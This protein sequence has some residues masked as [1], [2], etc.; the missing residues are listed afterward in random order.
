MPG[1]AC[2]GPRYH[3]NDHSRDVL[4][5]R[6]R[7]RWTSRMRASARRRSMRPASRW[8]RIAARS[9]DFADRAAS[10]ALYRAEIIALVQRCRAPIWC[11]ST[12]PASC[13]SA[14]ARRTPGRWTIRGPRALRMSTSAMRPPPHSRS[15]PLPP[16]DPLA[17]FVHYN[18]WRALS[19]PPQDVPLA[20]CDARSVRR[21]GSDRRRRGIRRAGRAGV[22]VRGHRA[23]ARP[24][25]SLALVSGHARER[26]AGL[27]DPRQ[28]PGRAH[29]VP[30]VAFDN[31]PARRMPPRRAPASRCARSPC[32]SPE[33]RL[34]NSRHPRA[35]S[36]SPLSA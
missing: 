17:R 21:R 29:C 28:R 30:H 6:S 2:R 26:G 7:W 33:T 25:A 16:T 27:Q 5:H 14:N 20:V 24:R 34:P 31:P 32:G 3:A 1:A 10:A 23:G 22:V 19:A 9:A 13:A 15:A 11:W 8:L 36:S 35:S 4:G 12:V 18:V